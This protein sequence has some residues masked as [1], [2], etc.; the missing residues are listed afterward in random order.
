M[1]LSIDTITKNKSVFNPKTSL[2]NG[3]FG[4]WDLT[5]PSVSYMQ[6]SMEIDTFYVVP[7][8]YQMRPDIIAAIK[9]GDQGKV[10]SLLKFNQISNPF[11]IKAGMFLIMP[12][13]RSIED[14]FDARKLFNQNLTNDNTNTNP[15][16]VFKKNQEQKKFKVSEGRK[17]FI[18]SQ[19]KNKPAI[20][21]SPNV[22][23]PNEKST[24]KKDGYVVF[25]PN[26]GGGGTNLPVN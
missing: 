3:D 7:D 5:N 22:S 21:I 25:G 15:S 12:T 6:G 17:N 20:V 26:A 14:S 13:E 2:N 8:Y 18:N 4:I 23:Q 19:I 11:A 16:N 1:A 24:I 9:Y 10:G